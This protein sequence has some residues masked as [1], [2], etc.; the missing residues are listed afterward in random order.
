MNEGRLRTA[1]ELEESRLA[2]E[3]ARLA[4][5]VKE[6][7]VALRSQATKA[8]HGAGSTPLWAAVIRAELDRLDGMIQAAAAIRREMCKTVPE[9]GSA[10][11]LAAWSQRMQNRLDTEFST[12]HIRVVREVGGGGYE[13][14]IRKFIIDRGECSM[15]LAELK[16]Q[17]VSEAKMMA[18]EV[19]LGMHAQP[20]PEYAVHISGPVGAVNLGTIEG[21]MNTAIGSLVHQARGEEL[22]QG[23]KQL[24]EAV[25]AAKELGDQRREILEGLAVITQ[26]AAR[27]PEQ[28][29][30][31]LVRS[32]LE[33]WG[34]TLTTLAALAEIWSSVHPLLK[35]WF[36][37]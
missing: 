1:L 18:G 22:A 28:R 33:R 21:D 26:E 10:E 12:L 5:Q 36:G 16:G 37:L 35:A 6:K 31:W 25:G 24:A 9:L 32:L 2:K 14:E 15:R 11:Q 23:L 17:V 3:A 27:P 4:A 13:E 20:K 34:P 8:G 7:S 19:T 29:K 30:R